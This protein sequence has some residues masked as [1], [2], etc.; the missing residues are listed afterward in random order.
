MCSKRA[1][2][3]MLA[4]CW[5]IYI[6]RDKPRARGKCARR[7]GGT[8]LKISC[9]LPR[10]YAALSFS[11]SHALCH[12]ALTC[13]AP[14]IAPHP[15]PTPTARVGKLA[16][17]GFSKELVSLENGKSSV[18]SYQSR[19]PGEASAFKDLWKDQWDEIG[20]HVHE[21]SG[22]WVIISKKPKRRFRLGPDTQMAEY[23]LGQVRL[24]F[25]RWRGELRYVGISRRDSWMTV[26]MCY[27][28]LS[29]AA[30]LLYSYVQKSPSEGCEIA[31]N[32]TSDILSRPRLPSQ[33]QLARA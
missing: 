11:L 28:V 31:K 32:F 17:E 16:N 15:H 2:P 25:C 33:S 18:C 8:G 7:S 20:T 27:F 19:A 5:Q 6:C 26:W 1:A 10:L 22:G 23:L 9:W 24:I 13:F 12:R 14:S 4:F 3:A 21:I 29:P 30:T